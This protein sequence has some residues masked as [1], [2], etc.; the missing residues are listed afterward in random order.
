M[1]SV[2]IWPPILS[3]WV[4]TYDGPGSGEDHS[5]PLAVDGQGNVYV[6]SYSYGGSITRCDY[7]TIKYIQE[8]GIREKPADKLENILQAYPNPFKTETEIHYQLPQPGV[9][10]IAI[11]NVSGQRINTLVN[12]YKDAGCFTVCWD[13]QSQDG[14][15]VS[16][17]VYFCRIRAREYTSAKRILFVRQAANWPHSYPAVV[18]QNRE[19]NYSVR[20]VTN[21]RLPL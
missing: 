8:T 9:V 6:T 14:K 19:S 15:T 7:A 5:W 13:G 20:F 16:N 17:G 1:W 4:Q 10:T 2:K 21:E 12:E 3:Q 18:I 11:Y